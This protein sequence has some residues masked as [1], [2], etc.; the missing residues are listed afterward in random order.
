MRVKHEAFDGRRRVES[1]RI[2]RNQNGP[3]VTCRTEDI[4]YEILADHLYIFEVEAEH[5]QDGKD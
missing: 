5:V 2:M 4:R 3:V 1:P